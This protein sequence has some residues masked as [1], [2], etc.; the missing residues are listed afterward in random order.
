MGSIHSRYYIIWICYILKMIKT[1]AKTTNN[2]E[3]SNP[4]WIKFTTSPLNPS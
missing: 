3:R 1:M 4:F 2:F